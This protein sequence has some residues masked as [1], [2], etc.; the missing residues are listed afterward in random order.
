MNTCM[1]VIGTQYQTLTSYITFIHYIIH[2]RLHYDSKSQIHNV[3]QQMQS[4]RI[5]VM[6]CVSDQ[7]MSATR[8]HAP[9]ITHF[10][11]SHSSTRLLPITTCQL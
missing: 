3:N 8:L 9:I 7:N 2:Y 11:D 10:Y 6:G 4:A 5:C 1:L